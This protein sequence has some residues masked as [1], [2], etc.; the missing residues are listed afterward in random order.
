MTNAYSPTAANPP[1]PSGDSPTSVRFLVVALCFLMSVLLYV[2]RF[3]LSPITTTILND[4]KLDEEQ[5][6]RAVFAFFCAYALCQVPAGWLSDTWGARWTLALYVV[7]WSLAT[8]GLGLANGL[9]AI[10]AMRTVLGM[11]QAGAY[12][13]AASLLKRWIPAA[14]RARANNVVSMGGRAGNLLA[15]FVTPLLAVAAASLLGWTTGA[16]RTVLAL[17]G[18]LGLIWAAAFVW[19]YRDTPADHAWC[20]DAERQLI[21]GSVG[22]AQ[23]PASPVGKADPT[24]LAVAALSSPNL[25]LIS[26]MGVAVNVG[27]VFLVTWLPRFLIARHGAELEGHVKNPEVFTGMLTALAGFGG[28]VG[29]IVGGTAADRFLAAY[30]RRWGRRL[31]GLIAGFLACGM[32]LL[33]MRLTNVWPLVAVMIA[34]SFTIDFGLGA[35][36]ASY[37]DIG[38]RNVAVVLGIGNMCGNLGAAGFGWLIGLLA[39]RG[40]WN[41]VFLIAGLAMALNATGWLFFD[42]TRPVLREET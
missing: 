5:F 25:W 36:W 4:L 31:P 39:K 9:L 13:A 21:E 7:G 17:Y 42:A 22:S 18:A 34:I 32:Y 41:A 10:M 29:S 8:V 24:T 26:I 40:D 14:G 33:A 35:S 37:Q 12:P 15:Q 28:M 16:W 38:G 11:A 19:L 27:W 20:N 30:G 3:A 2:D 23:K 1:K 6:G